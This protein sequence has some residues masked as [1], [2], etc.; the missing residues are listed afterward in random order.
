VKIGLW[1]K[2][3]RMMNKN[4]KM[5]DCRRMKMQDYVDKGFIFWENS[6]NRAKYGNTFGDI[7]DMKG[8][9]QHDNKDVDS[10]SDKDV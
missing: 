4:G 9:K 3:Q 1:L 5:K 2:K 6:V 7:K 8:N 10:D